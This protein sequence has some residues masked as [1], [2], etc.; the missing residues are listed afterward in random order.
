[1]VLQGKQ[2][3]KNTLHVHITSLLEATLKNQFS[4]PNKTL[5]LN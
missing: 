1:M 2:K 3:E 5:N 4:Y